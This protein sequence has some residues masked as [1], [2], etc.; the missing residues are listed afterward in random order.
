M[1]LEKRIDAFHK[2]GN[3]ITTLSLDEKES[4]LTRASNENPWFNAENTTRAL[5]GISKF[6][7]HSVLEKWVYGYDFKSA[8]KKVGVAMA[9]NI[10]LVG[11][12]DLMCVLLS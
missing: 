12:H 2:L 5:E 1:T 10:P 9:G 11:F 8:P 7:E 6:L 4:L 3:K